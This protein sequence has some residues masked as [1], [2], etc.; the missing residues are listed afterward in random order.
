MFAR[1]GRSNPLVGPEARVR[2]SH[3]G[4]ARLLV[5]V[6]LRYSAVV[7]PAFAR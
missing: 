6:H 4:A 1:S 7:P 5:R 3:T 2:V